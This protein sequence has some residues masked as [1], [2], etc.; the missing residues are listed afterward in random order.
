MKRR[1]IPASRQVDIDAERETLRR[2]VKRF[3]RRFNRSDWEACFSLIDPQLADAGRVNLS[4]YA[5]RMGAFKRVYGNLKL[6]HTRI[7]MH[8][9]PSDKQ[10]D[11]RPFAYVYVV[12][13][14]EAHEFHMFRERWIKD[15][16]KWSTRVV[17]L[18]PNRTATASAPD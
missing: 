18:V 14:D 1:T 2:R 11:R 10:T 15:A 4:T 3:Y 9:E 5:D 12:W 13:Q 7:S 17:G 8:F 6:W 16:G